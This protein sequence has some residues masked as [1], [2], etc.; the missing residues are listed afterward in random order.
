MKRLLLACSVVFAFG[1][2]CTGAGTDEATD[3]EE[4]DKDKEVVVVPVP[5][6]GDEE[7]WC[8]EYEDDEGAKKFALVEGP[9]ECNDKFADMNGRWVS[10][11]ECTPCCCKSP[12]D[13]DNE[14]KGHSFELT[15]PTTC[16]DVGECAA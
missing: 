14:S 1:A 4:V 9:G 3:G 12:N 5:E 7:H 15:T 2:M 16:A 11:N 8:C 6:D 13:P 10:G